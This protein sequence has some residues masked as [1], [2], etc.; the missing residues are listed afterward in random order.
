[1]YNGVNIITEF[2][3]CFCFSN[4]ARCAISSRCGN[5]AGDNN[6]L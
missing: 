4:F 3:K 2:P 5:A 1:M 6:A